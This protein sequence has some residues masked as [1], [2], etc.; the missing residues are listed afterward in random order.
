MTLTSIHLPF[1]RPRPRPRPC[2]SPSQPQA[3]AQGGSLAFYAASTINLP[4]NSEFPDT[5]S[6]LPVGSI[7]VV[8]DK[9]RPSGD[10]FTAQDRQF[11]HDCSDMVARE[12]HLGYEAQCREEEK[13]QS[14]F[15]GAFLETVLVSKL[16]TTVEKDARVPASP[17]APSTSAVRDDHS[18][19]EELHAARVKVS[20][21][22]SSFEV[23]AK[24]LVNLTSATSAAVL[25]LR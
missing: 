17:A 25:D 6:T 20:V 8:S 21:L 12:F 9:P 19:A 13:E 10:D 14:T 24:E 3:L 11:L 7:C 16:D 5:P 18:T 23:A 22:G 4:T 15:L 2:S 1:L